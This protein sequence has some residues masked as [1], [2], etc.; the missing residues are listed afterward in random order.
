MV[1]AEMVERR[2]EPRKRTL[3]VARILIDKKSVISCRVKN[4][5]EHGVRL[6]IDSIVGVPDAFLLDIGGE[7][8]RKAQVVWKTFTDLGVSL[9]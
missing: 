8:V 1:S 3:K 7:G 4:L 2:R 5:S 9:H 6:E